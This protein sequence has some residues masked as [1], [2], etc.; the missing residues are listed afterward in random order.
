MKIIEMRVEEK[1]ITP[2][3]EV[4]VLNIENGILDDSQTEPIIDD[5]VQ[6]M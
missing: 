3:S 2:K 1:Y 6:P 4:I 5:P